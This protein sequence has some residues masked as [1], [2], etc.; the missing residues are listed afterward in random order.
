[1][2]PNPN[3]FSKYK[4]SISAGFPRISRD[5]FPEKAGIRVLVPGKDA[6]LFWF[7]IY[8]A[9]TPLALQLQQECIQ[10][11]RSNRVAW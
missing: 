11:V 10:V 6:A 7:L 1:M 8:Y 2:C 4:C 5:K 3:S 9:A